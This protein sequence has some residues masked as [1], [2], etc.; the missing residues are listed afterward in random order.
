MKPFLLA[1]IAVFQWIPGSLGVPGHKSDDTTPFATVKNGTYRGVH[2][3]DYKQDFFLGIPFAKPPVGDLRFRNPRSYDTTWKGTRDAN[4]YSPAC[5][6]YGDCLYLN[7]IRPSGHYNEKL[8]VAVWIHGGGYYQGSGVDLRYNLTFIVEQSVKIGHP[9]IAVNINYRLGAFGF[10]NSAEAFETGDSNMGFRDQRLSLHWIHE[11]IAAFGG[12]PSKVTIWGQS[13]GAASVGA[14]ILAYNGRDDK[15]FRSAILQSGAPIS[16]ASQSDLSEDLYKLLL[17]NTSCSSL[18]CLRSLPFVDLNKALNSTAFSGWNPKID[19][20]FVARHSS[21]QLRDGAFVK[22]PIIIGATTDEGT[23]FSKLG[24]NTTAQF[25]AAIENSSPPIN[26]YF[27]RKIAKAY[28][29]QSRDQ[30]LHNL[31]SDWVPPPNYGKQFRRAATYYGDVNMVAPRRLAAEV[32]ADKGLPVYSYRFDAIPAWAT[33]IQGATH[34]VD[35]AFSMI[36]LNGTGYA[37]IRKPPFLGL[38]ESY[39]DLAR[40]MSGDFAKFMATG[41]PNG[42]EGRKDSMKSL[43]KPIPAWPV[44]KTRGHSFPQN[45]V[46]QGNLS[47][48]VEKDGWRRN[49]IA[50]LNS[51]NMDVYDR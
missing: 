26:K 30:V 7:V 28:P 35:V 45:F 34:F 51:V 16:L 36:N 38:P 31:A 50:L 11:N 47:S 4:K 25:I 40:L 6:G 27:A 2:S 8:P 5:V 13:A 46:Y 32:W 48:T 39:R 10:L 23:S 49:S 9:I 20:D 44:Y 15:L 29:E 3:N 19:G 33:F 42:W 12:D 24:I 18:E 22:V 1:S 41:D 37:P 17:K 43:G 14:Q 21:Q